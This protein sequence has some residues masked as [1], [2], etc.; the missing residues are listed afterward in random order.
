M[1]ERSIPNS[2]DISVL[3]QVRKYVE[4]HC[5]SVLSSPAISPSWDNLLSPAVKRSHQ[6]CGLAQNT[7]SRLRKQLMH[8]NNCTPPLNRSPGQPSVLMPMSG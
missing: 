6:F 4:N 2:G 3:E 5:I 8:C 1:Y 7:E